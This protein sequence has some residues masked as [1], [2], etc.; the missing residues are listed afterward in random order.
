[1]DLL[2]YI[3]NTEWHANIAVSQNIHNIISESFAKKT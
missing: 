2:L 3:T 1:M